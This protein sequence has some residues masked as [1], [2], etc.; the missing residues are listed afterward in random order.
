M[1]HWIIIIIAIGFACE[2][3]SWCFRIC[4]SFRWLRKERSKKPSVS[5]D[6]RACLLIPV[7]AEADIIEAT[8]EYFLGTFLVGRDGVSLIFVT[9]EKE[10]RSSHPKHHTIAVAEKLSRTKEKIIHI[11]CPGAEGNMAH[12]LNYAV[13]KLIDSGKID[14]HTLIGIYNADSRPEQETLDWVGNQFQKNT[15]QAFQQYGCYTENI[16]ILRRLPEGAVLVSAA[17]WQTRWAIGFEIYNS[18][19]QLRGSRKRGV[20]DLNYPFNYCI[21]HGLFLTKK[22]FLKVGGFTEEMHN[23]D[24]FLGLQ[25]C[26]IQEPLMPVPYFDISESP[27]SLGALYTQKS[28][29]FLGPLQAYA[30][31]RYQLKRL[32][33]PVSRKFRLYVLASKLFSHAIFWIAGPTLMMVVITLSILAFEPSA[34]LAIIFSSIAFLL[35]PSTISIIGMRRLNVVSP[36]IS[37]TSAVRSLVGGSFISY[38]AH[39]ASAYRGL[40][41]YLRHLVTGKPMI[42]EKTVMLHR[43]KRNAR[44]Y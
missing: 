2:S 41:K 40:V 28:N 26:D 18:L 37:P 4:T 24:S 13:N 31:A 29:W 34:I 7:L 3:L 42:K 39:G 32:Q 23:E 25:L 6:L 22:I 5:N 20:I 43:Q 44:T 21:G 19:K 27:D 36:D 17:L 11:H 1:L 16:S 33:Y 12:Q 8:A 14:D 38:M 9:T 15:V 10:T 35:I 30:Y